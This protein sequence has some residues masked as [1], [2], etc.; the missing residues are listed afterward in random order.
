MKTY[1][2]YA[3]LFTLFACSQNNIPSQTEVWWT[4]E[5]RAYL[6]SELNRCT[7]EISSELHLLTIEQWHFKE[8]D[9]RW[10]IAEVIEHLEM[11]TLL[12]YRDVT[13]A[14]RGPQQPEF[15]AVTEGNDA[16]FTDYATNTTPGQ[17]EWYVEPIGRFE[18][19]QIGETAFYTTRRQIIA[20]VQ[21]TEADL[22]KKFTFRVPVQGKRIDKLEVGDV[23]DLHQVLLLTIAHTDRHLQQIKNIKKHPDY[24]G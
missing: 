21:E 7:S 6:I 18:N 2:A 16:Y 19:K 20:F 17:A 5:D 14:A 22:R 8:A 4:P 24:P 10:S 11:Q 23:R 15:R 3:L 1:F 12:H 9:D 13:V